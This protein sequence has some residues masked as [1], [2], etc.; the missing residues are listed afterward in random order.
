VQ[1][2]TL[3][4][5]LAFPEAPRWHDGA[6]WFSD[7]Y[8]GVIRRVDVERGIVESVIEVPDDPSGLGWLPDGRLLVVAM[9]Q[10]AVLRHDDGAFVQHADLSAFAPWPCNDMIVAANGTAYVGHFGWDRAHQS[11]PEA[12]ASLLRVRTDGAV[13]VAAE[14]MIFPNGMALSPDGATLI[15]A[16]SRA[17]RLTRFAVR[18]DGTLGD[19]R[20]F[21]EL[22]PEPGAVMAPPDGI[23]LDAEG[24][25]W[26]A[27][28]VGRRVL[29]VREGGEVTH[30]VRVGDDA[31]LAC[32][33]G[34]VDRTT[35]CIAS[36][37]VFERDAARESRSGRISVVSVDVPGVGAP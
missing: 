22:A 24:A 16:E 34:G 37:S 20:V 5:G 25:V 4:A 31:P 21:A 17:S 35:L 11:T 15:V 1:P 9:N 14:P 3:L 6:L 7:I 10:R 27:D 29:R 23:C 2:T 13:D 28:P 18:D 12:P 30:T 32:V 36:A 8:G 33:L 26:M 19:R